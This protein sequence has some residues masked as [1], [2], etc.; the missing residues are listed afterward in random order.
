[1]RGYENET[2]EEYTRGN[3]RGKHTKLV[4]LW[5]IHFSCRRPSRPRLRKTSMK[6]L[7]LAARFG[8]LARSKELILDSA[9]RLFNVTLP[10][11]DTVGG[12]ML[13]FKSLKSVIKEMAKVCSAHDGDGRVRAQ[14]SRCGDAQGFPPCA[15]A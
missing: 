8:A 13:A 12:R 5:A 11:A 9:K 4:V 3:I 7:T 6:H 15:E 10:I 14:V 1:M 2:G